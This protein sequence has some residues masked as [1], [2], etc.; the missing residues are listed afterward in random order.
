LGR[1]GFL[2]V[3]GAEVMEVKRMEAGFAGLNMDKQKQSS[4][5]SN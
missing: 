4:L 1:T 2:G 5:K 3:F